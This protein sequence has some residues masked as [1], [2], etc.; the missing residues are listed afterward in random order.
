MTTCFLVNFMACFSAFS[1]FLHF[2]RFQLNFNLCTRDI[3]RICCYWQG[4]LQCF[5]SI[6]F[7]MMDIVFYFWLINKKWRIHNFCNN[8]FISLHNF[9]AFF[10][11]LFEFSCHF[12]VSNNQNIINGIKN[13]LDHFFNF[14]F[15]SIIKDDSFYSKT[16]SNTCW[17]IHICFAQNFCEFAFKWFA[18]CNQF[19]TSCFPINRIHPQNEIHYCFQQVTRFIFHLNGHFSVVDTAS[20]TIKKKIKL[21][22]IFFR[23]FHIS[24][25]IVF[26]LSPTQN[27]IRLL[28]CL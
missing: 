4:K 28:C 10:Y 22:W 8:F 27:I 12:N 16:I 25:Q 14:F 21:F 17:E 20:Q 2:L 18:S 7:G 9:S 23:Y 5:I 11:P 24:Q 6:F 15:R 1:F 26:F 13:M 19:N 3:S